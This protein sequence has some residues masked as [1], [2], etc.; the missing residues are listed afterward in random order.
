[1][2]AQLG[3]WSRDGTPKWTVPI[4]VGAGNSRNPVVRSFGDAL[5]CAWIEADADDYEFVWG[6]W[7]GLDGRRAARQY[8]SE[9]PA[10]PRGT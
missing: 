1:M 7:W 8:G 2:R 10:R 9:P 4:A 3:V 6:G 5:F